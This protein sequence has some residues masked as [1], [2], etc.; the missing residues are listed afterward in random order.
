MGA[1][2]RRPQAPA[3][4][5]RHA[6]LRRR[7]RLANK[8]GLDKNGWSVWCN[9]IPGIIAVTPATQSYVRGLGKAGPFG[10]PTSARIEA[11]RGRFLDSTD[12]AQRKA[13]TRDLQIQAFEDVP[14]I[15]TGA[16]HQPTAFS[17]KLTGILNGFPLFH[18]VQKA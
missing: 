12:D 1:G 4:P 2:I 10:W 17:R 13:I 14:Y 15:P 8:E 11:R 18:N 6:E 7:P 16:C 5:A 3:P 9:F